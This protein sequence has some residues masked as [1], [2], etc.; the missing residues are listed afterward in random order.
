MSLKM[1]RART[2]S[3]VEGDEI[4][5]D[6]YRAFR[7]VKHLQWGVKFT[8]RASDDLHVRPCVLVVLK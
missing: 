4:V 6:A 2:A 8:I 7:R 5:L 1:E 3:N